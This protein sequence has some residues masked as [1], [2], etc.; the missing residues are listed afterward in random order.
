MQ[1][2]KHE[3]KNCPRCGE[4]FECKSNSI[5]LCQCQSVSLSSH[6]S[7]YVA[8]RFGD[9][10]CAECLTDLRTEYNVGVH[11]SKLKTVLDAR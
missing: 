4:E 11:K 7:D 10:L 8:S 3:I 9:C 1:L 5:S 6:Q 2:N